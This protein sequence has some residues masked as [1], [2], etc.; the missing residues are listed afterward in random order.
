MKFE[1]YIAKRFSSAENKKRM[2]RPA[3]RIAIT[4]IALGLAVM[5]ISIATVVGFKSEVS[6]QVIGF[7]SHIQILPQQ[8]TTD[9]NP[10]SISIDSLT[11]ERLKQS[12]NIKAVQHIATRSGIIH[13]DKAFKGVIL[14]GVDDTYNWDFFCKNLVT[15][16]TLQS[17]STPNGALIS[18]YIADAMMLDTG[19]RFNIYFVD[20]NL[21]ARRFVVKGIYQTTFSDYDKLYIITHS[22]T[23]QNVNGWSD[24]EYSSL[25][26]LVKD[27]GKCEQT[28]SEAYDIV[29]YTNPSQNQRYKSESIISITPT[30]FDWLKMLDM[31]AVVILVLMILVSGFC[32]ISGLLILILERSATIGLFKSIGATDTTIRRIFLAQGMILICR[33]LLW[34]NVI[35]LSII[36]T[37]YYTHIIPLDASS[38]YVDFVPVELSFTTW[39]IVNISLACIALL[40]LVG[41]SYL[42]TRISPAEAMRRD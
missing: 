38:Y 23:I 7:G 37:Q 22:N 1:Y 32:V 17:D 19:D 16:S 2:S 36:L 28:A 9:S 5:L 35:G 42:V 18:Q 10:T 12:A 8:E 4:G 30:I 33:G 34:G 25:E 13:T 41:P 40:M 29:T 14:K 31:N 20:K 3:V 26:L 27:F 6:R 15:G 11:E 21:R 24:K 39:F